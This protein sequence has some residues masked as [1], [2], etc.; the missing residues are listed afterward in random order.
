MDRPTTGH[1]RV[2]DLSPLGTVDLD[3]AG[4]RHQGAIRVTLRLLHAA[5]GTV[6]MVGDLRARTG[7]LHAHAG[8]RGRGRQG[9]AAR[10]RIPTDRR[11]ALVAEGRAVSTTQVHGQHGVPG[12]CQAPRVLGASRSAPVGPGSRG[13]PRVGQPVLRAQGPAADRDWCLRSDG[14]DAHPGVGSLPVRI[15][16]GGASMNPIRAW[17]RFL[18]GP[19]SAR[20]LAIFRI[21]YGLMMMI[22]LALMATG[23]FD[24][25]Y[26]GAGLLQGTE[27]REAAQPM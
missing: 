20:P 12:I 8:C 9:N 27:A 14:P 10:L 25:W 1:F 19:V 6:A 21:V 22:Y 26:T 4:L 5:V 13:V 11:S 16:E 23:E 17:N 2:R 18:F 7:R 15:V 3:H 24:L